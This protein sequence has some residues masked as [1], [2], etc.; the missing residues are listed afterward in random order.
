MFLCEIITLKA[1]IERPRLLL[2]TPLEG[3]INDCVGRIE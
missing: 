3:V 2:I 1:G